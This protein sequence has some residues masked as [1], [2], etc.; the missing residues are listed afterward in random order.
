M[1]D[2]SC[3]H[4]DCII[5]PV[6]ASCIEFI[7]YGVGCSLGIMTIVIPVTASCIE[8]IVYGVGCSLGIMTVLSQS[9]LVV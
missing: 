6:T 7:V 4:Y 1:C 5:I 8:F 2:L 3:G 9:L